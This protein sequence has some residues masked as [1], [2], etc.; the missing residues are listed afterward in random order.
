[1]S[2]YERVARIIAENRGIEADTVTPETTFEQ[3]SFDSLDTVELVMHFEEEFDISIEAPEEGLK[4]V[5][6]AVDLI[7][8]LL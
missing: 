7:D 8:S 1:M 3:L 4:T 2:T 5:Q 6:E